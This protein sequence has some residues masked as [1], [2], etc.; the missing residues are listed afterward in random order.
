MSHKPG[1]EMSNRGAGGDN[2]RT[3]GEASPPAR[4]G[5]VL[6]H[7]PKLAQTFISGEID[8]VERAG[9]AVQV[10]AMNAPERNELARPGAEAK[11]ARTVYLKPAMAQAL[12]GFK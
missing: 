1:E 5:Y 11:A 2:P 12:A 7:Y 10:F 8:A 3:E 6:T 9:T 4:V